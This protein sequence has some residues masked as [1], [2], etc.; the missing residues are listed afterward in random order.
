MRLVGAWRSGSSNLDRAGAGGSELYLPVHRPG[1][2]KVRRALRGSGLPSDG[3]SRGFPYSGRIVPEIGR[4]DIREII[5]QS[6]R[7]IY[8][9]LPDDAEIL[10][11]HHG[12]RL[13]E[14]FESR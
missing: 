9:I 4:E 6:Y 5:I 10:T 7:A 14:G 2:S 12:A 8:R 11:V 3:P 1:R 13:L